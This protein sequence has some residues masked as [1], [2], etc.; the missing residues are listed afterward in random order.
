MRVLS[1]LEWMDEF[2]L[3]LAEWLQHEWLVAVMSLAPAL[4]NC[5]P[6]LNSR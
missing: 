3:H 6:G 5:K 2:V 4:K 1:G